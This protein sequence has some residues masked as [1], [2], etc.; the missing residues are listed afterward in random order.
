MTWAA[1]VFMVAPDW[2]TKNPDWQ[3]GRFNDQSWDLPSRPI[4]E[5]THYQFWQGKTDETPIRSGDPAS[6]QEPAPAGT[7]ALHCVQ[8]SG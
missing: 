2:N 1:S 8:V 6:G 7:L 5:R 3:K 4:E